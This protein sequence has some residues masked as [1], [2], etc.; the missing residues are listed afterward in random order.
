VH[1]CE[2]P[3]FSNTCVMP[4]VGAADLSSPCLQP[5]VERGALVLTAKLIQSGLVAC[6]ADADR[7]LS[8]QASQVAA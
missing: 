6:L 7:R 3:H 5:S 4:H 1:M 8:G 2:V